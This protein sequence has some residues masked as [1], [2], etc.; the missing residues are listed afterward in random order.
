M[1]PDNPHP[2]SPCWPPP[3]CL[4]LRSRWG[5]HDGPRG[6]PLPERSKHSSPVPESSQASMVRFQSHCHGHQAGSPASQ[7][8]NQAR[9]CSYSPAG[10]QHQP[11]MPVS[12]WFCPLHRCPNK[13]RCGHTWDKCSEESCPMA[14]HTC[15]SCFHGVPLSDLHPSTQCRSGGG[16]ES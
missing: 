1:L 8:Q 16:I 10:V 14:G 15:R 2:G 6:T 3:T 12:S 7:N 11:S 13:A 9:P 4:Q 5:D